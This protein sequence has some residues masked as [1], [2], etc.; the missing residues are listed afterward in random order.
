MKSA[1]VGHTSGYVGEGG[2]Q[3][4]WNNATLGTSNF[5]P[6]ESHF[7]TGNVGGRVSEPRDP[8]NTQVYGL[9]YFLRALH[10]LGHLVL[11][12]PHGVGIIITLILYTKKL[13]MVKDMTYSL[14]ATCQ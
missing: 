14:K 5:T 7:L 8:W 9:Y 12:H 6:S 10:E 11:P 3:Q 1:N 4:H 13:M 2:V